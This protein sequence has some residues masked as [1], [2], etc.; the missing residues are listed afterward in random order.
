MENENVPIF[1]VDNGKIVNISADFGH[2]KSDGNG[3]IDLEGWE[4]ENFNIIVTDIG[5]HRS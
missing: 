1:M 4:T 3:N 5:N 2:R